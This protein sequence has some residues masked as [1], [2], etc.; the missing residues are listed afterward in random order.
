[1][2]KTK[3]DKCEF[4]MKHNCYKSVTQCYECERYKGQ[5]R[6]ECDTIK[7]KENCPHFKPIE[8]EENNK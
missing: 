6:C 8:S 7:D 3:C 1:M 4:G 2:K 5:M